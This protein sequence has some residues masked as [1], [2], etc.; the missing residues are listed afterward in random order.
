MCSRL[1]WET[2][3]WDGNRWCLWKRGLKEPGIIIKITGI[4]FERK[5][6]KMMEVYHAYITAEQGRSAKSGKK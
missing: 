6:D 5:A 3:N 2:L 1:L 4:R